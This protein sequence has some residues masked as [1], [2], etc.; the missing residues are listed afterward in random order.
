MPF[1]AGLHIIAVMAAI[2]LAPVAALAADRPNIVVVVVDGLGDL[3]TPLGGANEILPDPE[4]RARLTPNLDRLAELGATFAC[5]QAVDTAKPPHV[6]ATESERESVA[7]LLKAAGYTT[8]ASG[9]SDGFEDWDETRPMVK[10]K[11]VPQRWE[12]GP[13][14]P[15]SQQGTPTPNWARLIPTDERGKDDLTIEAWERLTESLDDQIAATWAAERIARP[16]DK[17]NPQLLFVQLNDIG[18]SLPTPGVFFDRF[19]LD[20][21]TLPRDAAED[22]KDIPEAAQKIGLRIEKMTDEER[23]A[24]IQAYLACVSQVDYALGKVLEAVDVVNADDERANDWTVFF[25]STRGYQ[26]GQKDIW[27]PESACGAA[28]HTN[29]MIYAPGITTPDQ[30]VDTPVSVEGVATTL[31]ALAGVESSARNLLL[32][33]ATK[34]GWPGAV[35]LT[36]VGKEASSLRSHRFR[37]IRYADGAEELY[38]HDHDAEEAHNLLDPNQTANIKLFGLSEPQVEA[39]RKWLRER[40]EEELAKRAAPGAKAVIDDHLPGD[41]NADG[42]V[43]AADST[44]WRDNLG[45]EVPVGMQGDGDFDGRVEED[46]R[47]VWLNNY[48]RKR[49][50]AAAE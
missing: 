6:L 11:G 2:A 26:I 37:L 3:A 36:K 7:T 1:Q 31:A 41:F 5:A 42:S 22:R 30:R 39:V 49:E 20:Q 29:L 10:R 46:D 15:K 43:D 9:L 50:P 28:T 14:N 21:I 47:N 17:N 25:V 35:A 16:S 38:D 13:V 23:R 33:L 44:V 8:A 19:P 12:T 4:I 40:L 34:G 32:L 24:A 48:G 27:G 18:I 45:K